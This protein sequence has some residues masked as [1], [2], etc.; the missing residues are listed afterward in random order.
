MRRFKFLIAFFPALFLL[1]SIILPSNANIVFEKQKTTMFAS[2]NKLHLF[3]IKN[4]G[5]LSKDVKFYTKSIGKTL[6]FTKEGIYTQLTSTPNKSTNEV[7]KDTVFFKIMNTNPLSII[8]PKELLEGKI[9]YFTGNNQKKWQKNI[10]IYKKIVYKDIYPN[11]DIL[12]YGNQS[13]LEYDIFVKPG[14]NPSIIKFKCEGIKKLT[15]NKRGELVAELPS[16]KVLIQ[17]K[18]VIYQQIGD[19][20]VKIKG[21]YS[22][23]QKN[24]EFYFRFNI[25]SYNKKYPLIIDPVLNFSTYFGGTQDDYGMGIAVDSRGY[26]YITGDTNSTDLPAK[27]GYQQTQEGVY[28]IFVTKLSP[29]GNLIYSTYLGG[30]YGDHSFGGIAVDLNGNVYIT[31]YTSSSDF[32]TKN[33]YQPYLAGYNDAFAA[34]LSTTGDLIYSTY[35][36]GS[37]GDGGKSIVV[38]QEGNA[39]IT[40][41]TMSSDFPVKNAQ[42][43]NNQGIYDAFITKLDP[44]GN[45]LY[46]TYMGGSDLDE[47]NSIAV[48]SNGNVFIVGDT[49]SSDFPTKNAYQANNAGDKDVFIAK[50][51]VSGNIQ[52][53]TYLGGSSGDE[54]DGITVDNNDYVYITGFTNSEDF[55]VRNAFQTKFGGYRDV[56]IAKFNSYGNLDYSTYLGGYSDDKGSSIAIDKMGNIYNRI[57]RNR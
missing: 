52:Y 40:G 38:D 29:T 54:G 53:S 17:E 55:P 2:F 31:G 34:K 33:A 14:A 37:S 6:Y 11:I 20:K 24:N 8:V 50:L 12:F 4:N 16:G 19:K 1:F 42:Q 32:P 56:F 26:I 36:G 30:S 9:N 39:Y 51:D 35:I 23:L 45:V 49:L 18:P 10:P 47:G 41:Y 48:D 57:Y 25:E 43:A 27:N 21:N 22:I 15:T 44:T 28:D 3:F 46:S 7:S 5:Q 13:K